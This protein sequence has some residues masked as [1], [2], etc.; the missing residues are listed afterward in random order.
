[1]SQHRLVFLKDCGEQGFF[2]AEEI[3][4]AAAIGSGERPNPREGC[5]FVAVLKKEPLGSLNEPI[6][7]I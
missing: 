6:A 4:Q 2:A 1:L 7:G 3:M 5:E